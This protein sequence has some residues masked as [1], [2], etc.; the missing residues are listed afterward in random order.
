MAIKFDELVKNRNSAKFVISAKAGIQVFQDVLNLG[1]RRGDDPRDFL[2]PHQ[3]WYEC[4]PLHLTT[5]QLHIIPTDDL[6]LYHMK[7]IS[8]ES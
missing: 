8:Q 3:I 6:Y 1:V 5:I 7:L 4:Y 2:Q